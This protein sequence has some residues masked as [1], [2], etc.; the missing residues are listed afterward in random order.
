[1]EIYH[2]FLKT[3]LEKGIKKEDRTGVGTLSIFGYQFRHD[4]SKGF[5]LITTKK[6]HFKSII[7]ELLWFLRGDSNIQYLKEYGVSIWDEWADE[8]GEL[9]PIYGVQWRRWKSSQNQ[10]IDQ[11]LHLIDQIK[12][13]PNSRRLLVTAWNPE[14]IDQMA[15]PPCHAFF[16]CYVAENK[17]SLH[18]YQRSGDAFL[19]VPFNIASYALLTKMIAH[20]CNLSTHELIF[21][22]GDVHIYH[23]HF[24]QVKIQ[25]SRSPYP[26]PKLFFS[27]EV[28]SIDDFEYEDIV[29]EGD[30]A[31]P[32]IAAEVAV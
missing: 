3:I 23:N 20:V 14:Y 25:L 17:L 16:Q 1:M 2:D 31:H 13:N 30:Q 19:G 27:R 22:L 29:I 8:N 24:E 4:L 15:L 28:K 6:V 9:G 21:C 7:Y 32:H 12:K 10:F 5:P 11:I 26:L 18:L